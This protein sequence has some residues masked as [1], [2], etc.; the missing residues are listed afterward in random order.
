MTAATFPGT[1]CIR[2][3][4][5]ARRGIGH[6]MRCIALAQAWQDEGGNVVLVSATDSPAL[7]ERLKSE[8]IKVTRSLGLPGS[9]E[10]AQDLVQ[11]AGAT[12]AT[13]VVLDGYHFGPEYRSIIKKADLKLMVIDDLADSDLSMSDLILNQNLHATPQLYENHAGKTTRL[14]TGL[15]HV[16]LRREFLTKPLLRERG[17]SVETMNLLVTLGGADAPNVTEHIMK[18]LATHDL[19]MRMHVTIIV[20]AANPHLDALQAALPVLQ[21]R[22]N[23]RLHINPP[24]VPELM[25]A[26]DLALSAA[27][28]S[29]WELACLGVPMALIITADNQREIARSLEVGGAALNLGEHTGFPQQDSFEKLANL[30]MDQGLRSRMRSQAKDLIDGQ[31][32]KRVVAALIHHPL[33]LRSATLEDARL[34]HLWANEPLARQM[35]FSAD[36]IPWGNHLKWLSH[37][38]GSN[39]CRLSIGL[40]LR[41]NPVGQVRL[42][43]EGH[44]ATLSI[45]IAPEAR[46]QGY[47]S[48]LARMASQQALADGWCSEV[49]AWVK[50]ENAASIKAFERAGFSPKEPQTPHSQQ[51]MLFV[52]GEPVRHAASI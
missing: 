10:D 38:L 1:L 44:T 26:A 14:L 45:S 51:A 40:D 16:L 17:V 22:H 33:R 28:S 31:G 9:I 49:H 30:M 12:R 3:D 18:M 34:L 6:V 8:R 39:D 19:P 7:L 5:D 27:G 23:T 2:A 11:Q 13:W 29:C 37:R 24:N 25:R 35:S 43:R 42:D 46:G 52:M 15:S 32:A 41:N 21:K 47:A 48:I 36:S 50:P 20:G 4:A